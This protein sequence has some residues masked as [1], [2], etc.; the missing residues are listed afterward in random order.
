MARSDHEIRQ[1]VTIYIYARQQSEILVA[2]DMMQGNGASIPQDI[3]QID[4]QSLKSSRILRVRSSGVSIPAMRMPIVSPRYS[5]QSGSSATNESPSITVTI[6]TEQRRDVVRRS[7]ADHQ[8]RRERRK[9]LHTQQSM[10][11]MPMPLTPSIMILI[12]NHHSIP[13]SR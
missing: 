11:M 1:I 5:G 6:R 10:P 12:H 4:A 3:T 7:I 9:R 8:A 2:G 13:R